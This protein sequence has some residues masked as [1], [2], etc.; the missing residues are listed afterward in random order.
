M[1]ARP[2]KDYDVVWLKVKIWK[3]PFC[4]CLFVLPHQCACSVP[5][6]YTAKCLVLKESCTRIME[7]FAGPY[8]LQSFPWCRLVTFVTLFHLPSPETARPAPSDAAL[9]GG[10]RSVV[11]RGRVE[12]HV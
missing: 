2:G 8:T 6:E 12:G 3:R 10:R 4:G 1:G 5:L 9:P 11:V 7:Q